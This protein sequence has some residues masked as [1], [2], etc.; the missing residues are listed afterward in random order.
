[1][2]RQKEMASTI[3]APDAFYATGNPLIATQAAPE[4]AELLVVEKQHSKTMEANQNPFNV[5]PV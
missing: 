3:V 1:M 5:Q 2:A 4:Q